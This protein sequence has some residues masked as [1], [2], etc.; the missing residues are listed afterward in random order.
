M[1]STWVVLIQPLLDDGATPL[2]ATLVAIV[3]P[4]N[5][6]IATFMIDLWNDGLRQNR[7]MQMARS[8]RCR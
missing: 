7:A 1:T 8:Q 5:V 4:V 3:V 6:L 2:N